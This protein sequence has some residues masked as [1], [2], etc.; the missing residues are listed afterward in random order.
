VDW[1]VLHSALRQSGDGHNR[2]LLKMPVA[3]ICF[4]ASILAPICC[5]VSAQQEDWEARAETHAHH[6]IEKNGPGTDAALKRELLQM[7][8]TDQEIRMRLNSV[9]EHERPEI[10]KQMEEN[11][12]R[13]TARMK[14]IVAA[15]GWPTIALVGPEASQAAAVMLTHSPD[16]EWQGMLLPRLRKLVAEEQIFGSDIAGLTDRILVSQGKLQ[17]FGTQF[18]QI[19]GKMAMMP[20][21]DSKHLE[22]RRAQYLLP[23]MPAYRKMLGEMY[24]MQIE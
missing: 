10:T 20:V 8:R 1:N 18:K 11:D 3:F 14:Q 24:H 19:D 16:H 15:K 22:Q 13:L 7:Y 9:P 17:L 6:L 4:G 2:R 21:R 12:V 5:Q 23:P